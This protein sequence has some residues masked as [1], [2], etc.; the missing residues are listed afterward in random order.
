MDKTEILNTLR[1]EKDR[2]ERLLAAMSEQQITAPVLD[3]NWSIKDVMAHLMTWQQRT[4][5]RLTAAAHNTDP[6][7]PDWPQGLDPEVEDV[8]KINDWIYATNREKP[9]DEI[10]QQWRAGFQ[11]VL[12]TAEAIPD[13]VL[14]KPGYFPWMQEWAIADVLQATYEHHAEHYEIVLSAQP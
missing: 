13:D 12:D 3:G 6:K 11:Q 5:A 14:F 9:W 10:F 4:N 1:D 8:Q 2:W 7:F